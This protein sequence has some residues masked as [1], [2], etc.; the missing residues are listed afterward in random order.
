MR[1]GS[2]IGLKGGSCESPNKTER[3]ILKRIES[4]RILLSNVFS[5]F[6]IIPESDIKMRQMNQGEATC[7]RIEP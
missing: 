1:F 7:I 6:R 5:Q 4:R 3:N 2:G